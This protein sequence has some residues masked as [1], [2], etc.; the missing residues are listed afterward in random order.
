MITQDSLTY[1]ARYSYY[2]ELL[3]DIYVSQGIS[4]L[5]SDKIFD[6]HFNPS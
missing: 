4:A 3:E 1:W 2:F 5:S 6:A